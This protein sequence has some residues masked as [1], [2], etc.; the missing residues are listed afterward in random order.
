MQTRTIPIVVENEYVKG[1]GGPVGAAGSHNDVYLE[2][3]FSPLWDELAKKIYW[4]D[5][6]GENAG[7]TILT[8]DM[9]ERGY[10]NVYFV[11][12]PFEAKAVEGKMHLN[13]KGV[14][15]VGGQ[16]QRAT[17]TSKA[18]FRVLPA[19]YYAAGSPDIRPDQATQLQAEI[20]QIIKDIVLAAQGADAKAAAQ[21]AQR[22]AEIARAAA[23][24]ARAGAG[25]N[26]NRAETARTGA[27]T[28]REGAET[29]LA[30]AEQARQ[31]ALAAQDAAEN[32]EAGAIAAAGKADGFRTQ[33]ATSQAGAAA[34]EVKAG[35][36]E[37]QA[38][39]HSQA[40]GRSQA[41]AQTAQQAA[42]AAAGDAGGHSTAAVASAATAKAEADRAELAEKG[43]AGAV[44][45]RLNGFWFDLDPQDGGLNITYTEGS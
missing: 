44:A 38:L 32:A 27:E 18:Y 6:N 39:A 42:E 14:H 33:A 43:A 13:I 25:D 37:A 34:S 35:E 3:T 26:A 2:I 23:E 24:A 20:D 10:S 30:K 1:A 36:H 16:E 7:L 29:A 19:E 40:A 11:P 17:L 41:A 21:A 4:T 31:D 15:V 22:A 28:A 9:L 5:A 8:T 12:I 45:A